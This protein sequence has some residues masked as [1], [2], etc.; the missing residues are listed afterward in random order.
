MEG[1]ME[2]RRGWIGRTMKRTCRKIARLQW[3]MSEEVR[4]KR[5]MVGI[6]GKFRDWK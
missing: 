4:G 6:G 5:E 3:K 2:R 1:G